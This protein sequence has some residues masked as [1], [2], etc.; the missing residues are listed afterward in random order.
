MTKTQRKYQQIT[1]SLSTLNLVLKSFIPRL[2]SL[3][4]FA[5]SSVKWLS[6]ACANSCEI[7]KGETFTSKFHTQAIYSLLIGSST[8][9]LNKL[10][11]ILA[12]ACKGEKKNLYSCTCSESWNPP[13]KCLKFFVVIRRT[14]RQ[15]ALVQYCICDKW[16]YKVNWHLA[17]SCKWPVNGKCCWPVQQGFVGKVCITRPKNIC[18]KA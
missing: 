3:Q 2:I 16:D 4:L 18:A 7:I 11:C 14:S 12:I 1:P 6:E 15:A 13:F 9:Q 5:H 10:A 17:K 8:T